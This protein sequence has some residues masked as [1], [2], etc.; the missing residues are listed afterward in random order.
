MLFI[1]SHSAQEFLPSLRT[2]T[3]KAERTWDLPRRRSRHGT[4]PWLS[5]Q[6]LLG[7]FEEEE[8][9]TSVASDVVKVEGEDPATPGPLKRNESGTITQSACPLRTLRRGTTCTNFFSKRIKK[10]SKKLLPSTSEISSE[11]HAIQVSEWTRPELFARI[12]TSRPVPWSVSRGC[13]RS[14][15]CV[16]VSR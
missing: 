3:N 1:A 16:A 6:L 10:E 7:P 5:T 12:L 11:S 2:L 9:G 8:E 4:S 13:G 14:Q 15:L